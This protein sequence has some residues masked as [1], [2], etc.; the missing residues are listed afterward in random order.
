MVVVVP[1]VIMLPRAILIG[2]LGAIS[3]RVAAMFP[4]MELMVGAH[5][6]IRITDSHDIDVEVPVRIG[7]AETG[8]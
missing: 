5:I 7:Y 2:L 3:F 6:T 4:L 1:R 8:Q